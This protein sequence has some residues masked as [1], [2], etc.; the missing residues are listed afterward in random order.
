MRCEG[1][2][3]KFRDG[4]MKARKND[5]SDLAAAIRPLAREITRI[6]KQAKALG[7]FIHDRELLECTQCGLVENVTSV[8]YW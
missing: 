6:K 7:L 2:A 8:V 1:V 5:I 4:E 3:F